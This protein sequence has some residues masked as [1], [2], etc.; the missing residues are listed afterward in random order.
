[1][2][3]NQGMR[4]TS[5]ALGMPGANIAGARTMQNPGSARSTIRPAPNTRVARARVATAGAGGV[6]TG[7]GG[8]DTGASMAANDNKLD[9][10]QV[11]RD[12]P[13]KKSHAALLG[14]ICLAILA[15]GGIGFGVWAMLDSNQQTARLNDRITELQAQLAEQTISNDVN[16]NNGNENAVSNTGEYIYVGEWGI[17]LAK[18]VGVKYVDYEYNSFNDSL[19]VYTTSKEVSE[20]QEDANGSFINNEYEIILE[21]HEAGT[22]EEQAESEVATPKYYCTFDGYDYYG[23]IS[24]VGDGSAA[25]VEFFSNP[26]N[27]SSINGAKAT[28]ESLNAETVIEDV[29]EEVKTTQ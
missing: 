21:R 15:A 1:M 25:L 16:M 9:G 4:N 28:D 10:K 23:I 8:T 20:F 19:V 7:A 17:K 6:D 2:E 27:Y 24:G 14:M 12:A 5:A 29:E 26:D 13:K 11:F 22:Y 3:P 18:P